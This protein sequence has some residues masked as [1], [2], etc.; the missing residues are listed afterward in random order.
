M[1]LPPKSNHAI[2]LAEAS[3]LTTNFR[4]R[5][6]S[7]LKGG[8]FWKEIVEKIISQPGCVGLRYY[9]PQ[10]DNGT[11]AIVLVGVDHLGRDMTEGYIGEASWLCPPWCSEP[12]ALNHGVE[13]TRAEHGSIRYKLTLPQR[14]TEAIRQAQAYR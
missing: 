7:R 5:T 12:N 2:T 8:M 9:Y 6:G 4:R 1:A 14:E 11:P 10:Q 13:I 3:V